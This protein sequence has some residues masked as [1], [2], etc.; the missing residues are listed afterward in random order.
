MEKH[1]MDIDLQSLSLKEL[2]ELESNVARTIASYEQRKRREAIAALEAVAR[3][4]GFALN[5]LVGGGFPQ[6]SAK[7]KRA[8]AVAK[9]RNPANQADTWSGR[10]RKPLWFDAALKKGKKP[11]DMAIQSH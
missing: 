7:Q 4:N 2:K 11:E 9:Y 1:V 8:P 5:D 6:S 10:G 3:D